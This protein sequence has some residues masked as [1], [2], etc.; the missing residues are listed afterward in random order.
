MDHP[1]GYSCWDFDACS[2]SIFTMEGKS[3]LAL[4]FCDTNFIS[5]FL[6]SKLTLIVY[7]FFSL[8]PFPNILL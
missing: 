2:I 7:T 8:L 1:S 5:G 4:E 3:Y 6:K